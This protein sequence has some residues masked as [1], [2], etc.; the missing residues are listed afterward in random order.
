M[1]NQ[2]EIINRI[3]DAANHISGVS[4]TS[5]ANYIVVSPILARKI[6]FTKILNYDRI[7]RI[8]RIKKILERV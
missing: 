8:E 3:N 2:R 1:S 6:K 4:R 7:D 5:Y